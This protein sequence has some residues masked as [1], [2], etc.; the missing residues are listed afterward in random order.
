MKPVN[1]NF[2]EQTVTITCVGTVSP[3]WYKKLVQQA[4]LCMDVSD[5]PLTVIFDV[6]KAQ[7]TFSMNSLHDDQLMNIY[8]NHPR[9]MET[10]I[11]GD[12]A[13]ATD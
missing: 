6:R 3:A 2:F 5:K 12:E 8:R 1:W 11:I 4:I 9:L 10:R 13:Y 7:F